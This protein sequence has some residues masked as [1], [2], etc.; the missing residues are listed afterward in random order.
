MFN[1]YLTKILNQA[2]EFEKSAKHP[3]T[4]TFFKNV[5]AEHKKGM[6]KR[7]F[8]ST[9]IVFVGKCIIDSLWMTFLGEEVEIIFLRYW[10]NNKNFLSVQIGLFMVFRTIPKN[11][12]KLLFCVSAMSM[13]RYVFAQYLRS[14]LIVYISIESSVI[15]PTVVMVMTI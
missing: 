15:S 10:M 1:N 4:E 8:A 11:L 3:L 7:S 6:K 12:P 5:K 9:L 14:T 2:Y 13:T